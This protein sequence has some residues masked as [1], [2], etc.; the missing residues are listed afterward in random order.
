MRGKRGVLHRGGLELTRV[1][2]S[3]ASSQDRD[4]HVGIVQNLLPSHKNEISL[5]TV[6]TTEGERERAVGA[7]WKRS[8]GNSECRL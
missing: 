1:G 4:D 3:V 6:T 8:M 2:A 7:H 5:G